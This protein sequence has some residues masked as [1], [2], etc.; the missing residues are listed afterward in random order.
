VK[1]DV[2]RHTS[3]RRLNRPPH[4]LGIASVLWGVLDFARDYRGELLTETMLV[5]GYN[6]DAA[7]VEGVADFLARVQPH[8]AYLS[9]PTRPPAKRSVRPPSE[10]ALVRAYTILT[11]Q[12]RSVELLA[13]EGDGPFGHT[14]D[15][16]RDL[17]GILSIHPMRETAVRRYLAEVEESWDVVEGL[18]EQHRLVRV[19]Y[20]DEPFLLHRLLPTHRDRAVPVA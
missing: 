14:G 11:R 10:G 3:W 8:R 17:L 16:E 1:V 9:V 5:E 6:D 20:R 15:A 18:L 4:S 19:E 2:R 12:V 7:C 13:T